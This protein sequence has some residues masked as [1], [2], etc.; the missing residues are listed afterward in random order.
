M[1]LTTRGCPKFFVCGV[2]EN[3]SRC[4]IANCFDR[5]ARMRWRWP[6]HGWRTTKFWPR[7]MQSQTH[8]ASEFGAAAS[9][10]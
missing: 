7:C 3:R 10:G 4:L 2:A 6:P 1:S 8:N 9:A 5:L